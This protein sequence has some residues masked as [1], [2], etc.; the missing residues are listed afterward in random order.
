MIAITDPL[1]EDNRSTEITVGGP[2]I[3]DSIGKRPLGSY[4]L[5]TKWEA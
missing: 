3:R 5:K 1:L 4:R 2:R